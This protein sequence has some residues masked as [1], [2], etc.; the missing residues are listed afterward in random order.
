MI[1]RMDYHQMLNYLLTTRCYF[2]WHMMKIHCT[3][4][5]IDTE[6]GISVKNALH[7]FIHLFFIHLLTCLFIHNLLRVAKYIIFKGR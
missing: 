1:W 6:M 4:T 3:Y 5:K 7:L 2:L